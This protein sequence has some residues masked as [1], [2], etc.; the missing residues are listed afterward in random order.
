MGTVVNPELDLDLRTIGL[1][2]VGDV[3]PG[4]TN[5]HTASSNH[6]SR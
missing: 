1:F 4:Q 2:D 3:E 5:M 6:S